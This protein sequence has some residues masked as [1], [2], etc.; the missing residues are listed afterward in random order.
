MSNLFFQ[1]MQLSVDVT[2]PE[3]FGGLHGQAIYIDTEGSFVAQRIG[4][5]AQATVNHCQLIAKST[6]DQGMSM[7]YGVNLSDYRHITNFLVGRS[8]QIVLIHL[9]YSS[10]CSKLGYECVD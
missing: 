6:N 4:Q 3:C 7:L 9:T 5:I 8:Y 1:S 10:Y 2:I